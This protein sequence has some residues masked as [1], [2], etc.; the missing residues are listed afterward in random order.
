MH[1]DVSLL[2]ETVSLLDASGALL[3]RARAYTDLGAALRRAGRP[4][5]A[6]PPLRVAVDLAHRAGAGAL[7][8]AALAELR[9]TGA[10]PRRRMISGPGALTRSERRIAELVA[11]GRRNREIA[12]VLVVTLATVEFHLA[13]VFRKLGITSRTE[14]AAALG[15]DRV[16]PGSVRVVYGGWGTHGRVATS[17]PRRAMGARGLEPRTS[18]L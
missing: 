2:Q 11:T 16:T 4:L 18:W 10:R 17:T 15:A 6:R 12:E 1:D 7:E 3:E 13:N 9:A 8:D 5:D 14:V